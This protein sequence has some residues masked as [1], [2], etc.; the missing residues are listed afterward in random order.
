MPDYF[1]RPEREV[2]RFTI[3]KWNF[4]DTQP[5]AIYVVDLSKKKPTCTCMSGRYRGYCK[6]IDMARSGNRKVYE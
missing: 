6:H 5:S 4:G 3:S 2:G 1:I